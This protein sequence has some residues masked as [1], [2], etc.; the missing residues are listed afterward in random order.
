MYYLVCYGKNKMKENK[1]IETHENN[2]ILTNSDRDRYLRN[3]FEKQWK[4]DPLF[5]YMWEGNELYSK[6]ERNDSEYKFYAEWLKLIEKNKSEIRKYIWKTFV[7]RWCWNWDKAAI[8]LT[9]EIWESEWKPISKSIDYIPADYSHGAIQQARINLESKWIP[10]KDWLLFLDNNTNHTSIKNNE[11]ITYFFVWWTIWNFDDEKISEMFTKMWNSSW[12]PMKWNNLVFDYFSAPTSW[13]E[14]K[15]IMESY[16]WCDTKARFE[17]WLKTLWIDDLENFEFKVRY[18][19]S[20]VEWTVYAETESGWEIIKLCSDIE[21]NKAW[22]PWYIEEWFEAKEDKILRLSDWD[23][24]LIKKWEFY[25]IEKSRRFSEEEINTYL[26]KS[27]YKM[28][29]TKF[30][31]WKLMKLWIATKIWESWKK[32]KWIVKSLASALLCVSLWVWGNQ[33]VNNQIKQNKRNQT[34]ESINRKRISV[35]DPSHP[36]EADEA[37]YEKTGYYEPLKE[38]ML[39]ILWDIIDTKNISKNDIKDI[40]LMFIDFFKRKLKDI[41][42]QDQEKTAQRFKEEFGDELV[43]NYFTTPYSFYISCEKKDMINLV[44]EFIN[45]NSIFLKDKH[46]WLTNL[47]FENYDF[48]SYYF[49]D[50]DI[51]LN[52]INED[53]NS[54]NY[55]IKI[56]VTW[57]EDVMDWYSMF[58]NQR[59]EP[60]NLKHWD[61]ILDHWISNN[62]EFFYTTESGD[63]YLVFFTCLWNDD[64]WEKWIMLAS[65]VNEKD[66]INVLKENLTKK[67]TKIR[68]NELDWHKGHKKLLQNVAFFSK[69]FSYT[70]STN[71]AKIVLDDYFKHMKKIYDRPDLFPNEYNNYVES[72]ENNFKWIEYGLVYYDSD[73][74]NTSLFWEKHIP[75]SYDFVKGKEKEL[76]DILTKL[77]KDYNEIG[78][79]TYKIYNDQQQKYI[80]RR[81]EYLKEKMQEIIKT[82]TVLQYDIRLE[83]EKLWLKLD[84]KDHDYYQ[85]KINELWLKFSPIEETWYK[86]GWYYKW[87]RD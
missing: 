26:E 72:V 70:F 52:K 67:T 23:K 71:E 1:S 17:N 42:K 2:E 73:M 75:L 36:S 11:K 87:I 15:D 5:L 12:N 6:L 49:D 44:Y 25:P 51:N 68:M 63:K 7:D 48:D 64:W 59:F 47:E 31:Q 77:Q 86:D 32:N 46:C 65:L 54:L 4:F 35:G 8:V 27:W 62:E 85:N 84:S 18:V 20:N 45:E 29:K 34:E 61:H 78:E 66:I 38:E 41:S 60:I 83:A 37:Y 30:K 21:D 76:V 43:H 28:K 50:K 82:C 10:V 39:S 19:W 53:I 58:Q 80:S 14:I 24:I 22:Y 33:F 57:E 55:N 79:K 56:R 69:P 40:E 16:T 3:I 9:D 13:D 81:I 74:W